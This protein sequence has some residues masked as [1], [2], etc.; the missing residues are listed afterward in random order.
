MAGL[1]SITGGYGSFH[2]F[3][4]MPYRSLGFPGST[5][6]KAVPASLDQ[7]FGYH[8]V[9]MARP[10]YATHNATLGLR[11]FQDR[12]GAVMPY[13]RHQANMGLVPFKPGLN[14]YV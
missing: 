11:P 1:Q 7:R 10:Q 14:I 3:R 12:N 2:A 5:E 6:A 8:H 4:M 13:L 9:P